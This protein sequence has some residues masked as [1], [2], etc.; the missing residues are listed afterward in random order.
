VPGRLECDVLVVGARVAGATLATMLGAGGSRVLLIDTASFPSTTLSTHFFRGEWGVSALVQ[1]GVLDEV[2]ALGPPKLA[3]Q[4]DY[5]EGSLEP[6]VSEAQSPGAL[7]YCLSVRREPLDDILVRRA[8]RESTVTLMEG[9]RFVDVI[10]DGDRVVGARINRD[11]EQLDVTCRIVVG[12]DGRRSAVAKAVAA[13]DE[14]SDPP[15]RALYYQYVRGFR[16]PGEAG[17]EFSLHGD[18][19]AYVFPSDDSLACVAVSV[20]LQR[21]RLMRASLA[22]SFGDVVRGHPAIAERFARAEP[23]SRVLGCGPE[24]SYVRHPVGPGWALVGDASIHQD[25]WS[26][27]GIDFATTHAIFLA[28]ALLEAGASSDAE[29]DSMARYTMRRDENGLA[30]YRET[31]EFAADISRLSEG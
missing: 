15:M 26:G 12:A 27:R 24:R 10:R 8:A 11:G 4:Y 7:G 25:P 31:T 18:E 29:R 9:T 1:L 6:Q 5:V 22:T 14:V 3:C 13:P 28:E 21:F 30:G 23:T 17:P 20:N 19:I 16:S 2:L